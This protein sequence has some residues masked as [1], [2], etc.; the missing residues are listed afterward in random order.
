MSTMTKKRTCTEK[1]GLEQ[2][3]QFPKLILCH[4]IWQRKKTLAFLETSNI[5]ITS[6]DWFVVNYTCC[7]C[8]KD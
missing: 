7:C 1:V 3:F 6:C 4:K 5:N 2:I 8:V